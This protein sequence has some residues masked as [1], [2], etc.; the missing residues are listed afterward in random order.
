MLE[1][2]KTTKFMRKYVE[3]IK[4]IIVTKKNSV[5]LPRY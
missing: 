3:N 5:Y 1:E 4:N 2:N